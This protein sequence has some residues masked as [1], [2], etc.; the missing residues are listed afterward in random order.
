MVQKGKKRRWRTFQDVQAR[1]RDRERESTERM[2][3]QNEGEHEV[4]GG[5][6]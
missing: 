4:G 3:R 1:G 6:E 5:G 2:E